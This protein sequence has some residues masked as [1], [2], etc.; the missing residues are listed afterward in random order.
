MAMSSSNR[1]E[2]EQEIQETEVTDAQL[3]AARVF[4]AKFAFTATALTALSLA[5]AEE[6][7]EAEFKDFG[8]SELLLRA[9]NEMVAV[10]ARVV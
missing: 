10:D 4:L 8:A 2:L 6:E 1:A 5:M 9:A 3:N 7:T